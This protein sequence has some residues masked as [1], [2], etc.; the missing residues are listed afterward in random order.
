MK[1][2][3]SIQNAIIKKLTEYQPNIVFWRNNTGVLIDKTG[4]PVRFGLVGSA[5]IIGIIAPHGRWLAIEC[6]TATGKQR[7]E[8][9]NFEAMIKKMGG[10]YILA[11]SPE[12]IIKPIEEATN[13]SK[14][15]FW[16]K[17]LFN[18]L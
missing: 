18:L 7:P 9:K 3:T 11:R 2:E 12:D 15:I 5:D 10:V 1:E 14:I 13:M 8:Q 6:K 16:F 4:R 17:K